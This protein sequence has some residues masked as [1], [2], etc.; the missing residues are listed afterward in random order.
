M[1]CCVRYLQGFRWAVIKSDEQFKLS[2]EKR[3]GPGKQV[4]CGDIKGSGGRLSTNSPAPPAFGNV[5]NI[6]LSDLPGHGLVRMKV[7][8]DM[9]ISVPEF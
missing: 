8:G 1:E 3:G 9:V 6:F 7:G 4:E 2:D 5:F